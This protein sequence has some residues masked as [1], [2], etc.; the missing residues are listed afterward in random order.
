MT[1]PQEKSTPLSDRIIQACLAFIFIFTPLALGGARLYF[2]VPVHIVT[3]FATCSYLSRLAIPGRFSF[4]PT[5]LGAPLALFVALA[6]WSCFNSHYRNDSILAIFRLLTYVQIFY[7]VVNVIDTREKMSRLVS[8]L[9]GMA[10]FLS[11]LGLVLYLGHNYYRYWLPG[12]T[13]SAT[14]MNRDHFAGFLEMVIPLAAGFFFTR[15]EKEKK[16]LVGF[17]VSLML[18]AFVMAAS[19]GAWVSLATACLLLLPFVSRKRL[20]NG[21]VLFEI[22]CGIVVFYSLSHFDLSGVAA[23]ARTIIEGVGI[24]ETRIQIWMGAVDLIKAHPWLGSGIGTFIHVFPQYRPIGIYQFWTI[25]YAH[26]DWLQTFVELGLGGFLLMSWLVVAALWVGLRQFYLTAS[27]FKRSL[28][29]GAS[30]GILSMAFHS[31]VD[32]NLHIPANAI[33]FMV[34]VGI[35]MSLHAK[36]RYD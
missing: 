13:L 12:E 7:L 26:N 32:F 11:L 33:T 5:L 22:I 28:S 9:V 18:V 20:L 1:D 14:Y 34:L 8:I 27:S 29:L 10:A 17:L 25:D 2:L 4:K 15:M 23:R 30:I 16:A 21:A 19:R 6:A 24:D 31:F 35:I 3:L 36:G